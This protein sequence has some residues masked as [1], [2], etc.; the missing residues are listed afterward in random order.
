MEYHHNSRSLHLSTSAE[1]IYLNSLVCDAF[2]KI[3]RAGKRY[4]NDNNS[5]FVF[6]LY[7]FSIRR[8]FLSKLCFAFYTYFC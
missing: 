2:D 1:I 7:F 5:S 4:F 8:N 3:A 6:P